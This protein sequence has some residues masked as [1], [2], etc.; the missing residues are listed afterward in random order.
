MKIFVSHS[1]AFNFKKEL[2]EPL[3]RAFLDNPSVNLNLPHSESLQPSR[4]Q[5][6]IGQADLLVA[7]VSFP[8]TGS[9]IEIGWANSKK[10]PVLAVH[11]TDHQPSSS[12]ALSADKV[13][14]YCSDN[15]LI[16]KIKEF[17]DEM[18]KNNPEYNKIS[19]EYSQSAELRDDRS[20]ILAPTA[21]KLLGEIQSLNVLDLAC[22]DG[23]FT[24]LI[25]EW[26]AK[27]VV[28]IDIS[29]NM[30]EIARK[31]EST[32]HHEI[33]YMVGNASELPSIGEFDVVFAGFLL[34]YAKNREELQSMLNGI[35]NSLKPAGKFVCFNENPEKPL[36]EG[37]QYGV[38][39]LGPNNIKDG[40]IVTRQHFEKQTKKFEFSHFHYE[41]DTYNQSLKT[42]GFNNIEWTNFELDG[43]SSDQEEYW[44]DYLKNFSIRPMRAIKS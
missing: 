43:A 37:I 11:K 10:I 8:S 2:Y 18:E 21:K 24:R 36:H 17:I 39:T 13:T 41:L 3:Q 22:G 40:D 6:S 4:T 27:R 26:G 1:S 29:K 44:N 33:E 32:L 19:K 7:E 42:A 25:K 28:G 34:H 15:E 30:I 35:S 38:K 9:G 14:E 12:V 5:K 31:K 20:Q 16:Y 23:Y